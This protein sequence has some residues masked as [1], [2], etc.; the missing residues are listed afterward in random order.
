M[1][2]NHPVGW[3]YLDRKPGSNY[4][5]LFIKGR[6]I[7]ARTLYGLTFSGDDWSGRSPRELAA[8][9]DLPLEAVNEAIAYCKAN[10]PEILADWE[11]DEALAQ[12]TVMDQ[13]PERSQSEPYLPRSTRKSPADSA[14]ENIP[15]SLTGLAS[16]PAR[17]LALARSRCRS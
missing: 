9:N 6:N 17:D 3:T 2:N 7:A 4:Q 11:M 8:D 12:A 5:Q 16:F 15:R 1:K 13:H 14:Y 10:P